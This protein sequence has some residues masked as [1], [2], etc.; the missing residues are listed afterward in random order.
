MNADE[1]GSEAMVRAVAEMRRCQ[2]EYF[3]SRDPQTLERCKAAEREV[4]G[5]VDAWFD[6]QRTFD[7]C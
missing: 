1:R 6:T 2:K 4:D 3:K 7:F 5:L